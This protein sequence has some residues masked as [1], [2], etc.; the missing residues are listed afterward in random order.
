MDRDFLFSCIKVKLIKFVYVLWLLVLDR[1]SCICVL[2]LS[3]L[4]LCTVNRVLFEKNIFSLIFTIT[5][6]H[7]LKNFA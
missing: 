5:A 1:S 6:G 3:Y 2:V 4:M 7:K